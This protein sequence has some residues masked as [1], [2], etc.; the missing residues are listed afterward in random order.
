MDP[1]NIAFE[2]TLN[3]ADEVLAPIERGLHEYNLS[4]LGLEVIYN[5]AKVAITARNDAGQI[6]GG[7]IGEFIWGWLHIQTLWVAQEQRG[8][9]IGSELL[10]RI[11]QVARERGVHQCTLETT[12]FQARDFYLKNGFE[13]VGAEFAAGRPFTDLED[14][15]LRVEA[16]PR[17]RL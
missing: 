2:T 14:R 11:Q 7:I 13:I 5:Y 8:R 17:A 16:R 1:T 4:V 12:S 6:A 15:V 3:Q 10:R 9:D